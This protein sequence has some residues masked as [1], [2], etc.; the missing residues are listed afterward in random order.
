MNISKWQLCLK[1]DLD[2]WSRPYQLKTESIT[3]FSILCRIKAIL[4]SKFIVP[5]CALLFLHDY[6]KFVSDELKLE[7]AK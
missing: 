3:Y 1:N 5:F 6:A 7:A 4:K 2:D